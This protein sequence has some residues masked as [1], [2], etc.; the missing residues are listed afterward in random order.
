LRTDSIVA[1]R[2]DPKNG[3]RSSLD[4]TIFFK[5]KSLAVINDLTIMVSCGAV[6]NRGSRRNRT[7]VFCQAEVL[8]GLNRLRKNSLV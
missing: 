6:E 5:V 3:S 1:Q 7:M 2:G 4:L 8:Q